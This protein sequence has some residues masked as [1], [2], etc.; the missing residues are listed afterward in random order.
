MPKFRPEPIKQADITEY[1][2]NSDDLQ[3]EINIFRLCKRHGFNAVHGGTYQD[4]ITER[5]RQF[6]IRAYKTHESCVIHLAVEC[7]NLR[8]N[9]PLMVSRVPRLREE[10]YHEILISKRT[11]HDARDPRITNRRY[12]HP[13]TIFMQGNLVGK[14]TTQIGRAFGNGDIISGDSEVYEKWSQAIASSFDLVQ[15]SSCDDPP[16]LA[17]D[18]K[19]SIVQPMLVVANDT[20]WVVDYDAEGK[21]IEDPKKVNDCELYLDKALSGKLAHPTY[22]FSHLLVFT[23]TGFEL[24]LQ[25]LTER[26]EVWLSLFPEHYDP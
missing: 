4:P 15:S 12:K 21:T 13:R 2:E 9:Y 7:K 26:E 11:L 22:H 14:A 18:V 1:L 17:N 23:E 25:K 16:R 19:A 6:D 3:F 20:L 8:P 5:D 10:S 24:Y